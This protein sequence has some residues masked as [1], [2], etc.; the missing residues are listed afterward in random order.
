[1]D[2][3]FGATP[4][5]QSEFEDSA[6]PLPDVYDLASK[7][8]APFHT[9]YKSQ[10]YEPTGGSLA[11]R[12]ISS[13]ELRASASYLPGP[14]HDHSI[15]ISYGLL[16]A[17]W[18]DAF[19]FYLHCSN[20]FGATT[21]EE[22]KTLAQIYARYS[23]P[24]TE[25]GFIPTGLNC[26]VCTESLFGL[27]LSW[28]FGHEAGHLFQNHVALRADSSCDSLKV[29]EFFSQN[30]WVLTGRAAWLSHATEL[31]ADYEGIVKLIFM[32]IIQKRAP[33]STETKVTEQDIWLIAASLSLLFF[34]FWD[35][36]RSPFL[37]EAAGSH[38]HPGI[39]FHMA[40]R[41]L[42]SIINHHEF[43]KTF[44]LELPFSQLIDV[45][46]EAFTSVS[47][48]WVKRYGGSIEELSGLTYLSLSASDVASSYLRN[49]Y[50]IWSE[51]AP[52]AKAAHPEGE[53]A[54]I[55]HFDS[56]L[57]N[58]IQQPQPAPALREG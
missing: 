20:F 14:K 46:E 34:R 42:L 6:R 31:A 29:S 7:I 15:E 2:N 43:R 57:L 23:R 38:P 53:N 18:K 49:V 11:L 39:R 47:L 12:W 25:D 27:G 40:L 33:G 54:Q 1:M 3:Y 10:Y 19:A 44:Q 22:L 58:R 4:E 17:M 32:V 28:L 5:Q 13:F 24:P 37:A 21:E 41:A 30:E 48:F 36:K 50:D 26:S 16:K 56:D 45:S 55:F 35:H 52:A 51:I 9:F 8:L